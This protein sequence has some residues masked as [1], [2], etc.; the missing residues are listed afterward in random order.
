[1]DPDPDP[2]FLESKFRVFFLEGRSRIRFFLDGLILIRFFLRIRTRFSSI[3]DLQSCFYKPRLYFATT[4]KD[5]YRR[6]ANLLDIEEENLCLVLFLF[7][8]QFYGDRINIKQSFRKLSQSN[9][10]KSPMNKA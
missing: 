1:M 7:E 2:F 9:D 4:Q 6:K 8:S 5:S 3:P 10:Q